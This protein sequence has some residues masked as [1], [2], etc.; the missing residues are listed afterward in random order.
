MR[1]IASL[2]VLLVMSLVSACSSAA[3]RVSSELVATARSSDPSVTEA[4]LL[5]GRTCYLN[6]CATCH[7]LPLPDSESAAAWPRYVHSMGRRAHLN[8]SDQHDL[9]RYLLAARSK[10]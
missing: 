7:D 3:P 10:P 2:L 5:H 8:A 9:L 6:R 4:S 1:A